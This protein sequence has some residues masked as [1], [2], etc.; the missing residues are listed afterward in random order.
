MTWPRAPAGQWP[1]GKWVA[2]AGCCGWGDTRVQ[3][4]GRWCDQWSE[5]WD[6][7][8]LASEATQVLVP[9][10]GPLRA[11]SCVPC[12]RW[13][14]GPVCK[15]EA[16]RGQMKVH[17]EGMVTGVRIRRNDGHDVP[18]VLC[19]LELWRRKCDKLALEPVPEV[20]SLRVNDQHLV[21]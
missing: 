15:E 11:C 8:V 6:F 16:Q 20:C 4:G 17:P 9:E 1:S 19:L 10:C 14:P 3:W 18:Q 5:E 7:V 2:L 13:M 12:P 21:G